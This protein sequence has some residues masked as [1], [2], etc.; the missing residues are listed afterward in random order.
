MSVF[1][2]A[3]V[4]KMA[5]TVV[6]SQLRCKAEIKCALFSIAKRI[7]IVISKHLTLLA[8]ER[9]RHAEIKNNTKHKTFE[10]EPDKSMSRGRAL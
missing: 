2:P 6:G 1:L 10:V 8:T 4:R 7:L 9:P 5:G 3:S